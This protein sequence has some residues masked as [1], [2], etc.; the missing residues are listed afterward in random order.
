MGQD[1]S[2]QDGPPPVI[3]PSLSEASLA[4]RLASFVFVLSSS[5]YTNNNTQLLD[6]CVVNCGLTTVSLYTKQ[7]VDDKDVIFCALYLENYLVA[8]G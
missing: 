8:V 7:K 5:A 2:F 6:N 1:F 3:K 4:K